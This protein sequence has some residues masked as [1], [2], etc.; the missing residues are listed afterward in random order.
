MA[1]DIRKI[2][3]YFEEKFNNLYEKIDSINNTKNDYKIVTHQLNPKENIIIKPN[4]NENIV[5]KDIFL[6]STFD[7][8]SYCEVKINFGYSYIIFVLTKEQPTLHIFLSHGILLKDNIPATA[9][10]ENGCSCA[11]LTIIYTIY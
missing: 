7:T 3:M 1:V 9:K 4:P 10:I 6:S 2:M 5:I 8:M 11:S